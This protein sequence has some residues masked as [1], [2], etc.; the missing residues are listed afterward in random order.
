MHND[1]YL[2]LYTCRTSLFH[3]RLFGR[4]GEE[5]RGRAQTYTNDIQ[6]ADALDILQH[7]VYYEHLHSSHPSYTASRILDDLIYTNMTM[8]LHATRHLS[9]HALHNSVPY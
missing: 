6:T 1:G 2:M 3:D 5:R 9:R 4:Q 8:N 7:R